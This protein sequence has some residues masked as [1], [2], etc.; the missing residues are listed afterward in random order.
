MHVSYVTYIPQTNLN[1]CK[2]I[3]LASDI[4]GFIRYRIVR[5]HRPR[6]TRSSNLNKTLSNKTLTSYS[7]L[8]VNHMENDYRYS[9]C[10]VL[11]F[12]HASV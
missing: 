4:T 1:R 7:R 9:S 11:N 5:F 12:A 8:K 2:G 6:R 3:G 10:N